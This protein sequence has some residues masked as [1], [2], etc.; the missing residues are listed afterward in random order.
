MFWTNTL[1][2]TPML[3]LNVISFK[4]KSAKI[5]KEKKKPQEIFYK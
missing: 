4:E 5:T 2:Y 1:V 3:I